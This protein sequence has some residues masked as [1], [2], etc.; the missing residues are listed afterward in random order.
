ML[1]LLP[2]A[3]QPAGLGSQIGALPTFYAPMKLLDH[4]PARLGH[5]VP[6]RVSMSSEDVSCVYL[7]YVMHGLWDS[8]VLSFGWVC[9]LL[10]ASS[11]ET[12]TRWE[13]DNR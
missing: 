5:Q 9:G 11:L 12:A 3:V 13:Y 4:G 10:V 7:G 8:S 6:I 1:A 2:P